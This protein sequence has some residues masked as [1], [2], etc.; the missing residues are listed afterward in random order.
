MYRF[1]NID[2][3]NNHISAKT[4]WKSRKHLLSGLL[5]YDK[6]GIENETRSKTNKN[7]KQEIKITKYKLNVIYLL[8]IIL[9]QKIVLIIKL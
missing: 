4:Q 6:D 8:K 2:S 7:N 3:L 5:S 9:T 1:K